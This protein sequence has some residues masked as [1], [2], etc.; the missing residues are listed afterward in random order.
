VNAVS[1]GPAAQST[2]VAGAIA[3]PPTE[4]IGAAPS[5]SSAMKLTRTSPPAGIWAAGAGPHGTMP[6]AWLSTVKEAA[7]CSVSAAAL[8]ARSVTN[9][10]RSVYVPLGTEPES[11]KL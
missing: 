9:T 1:P 11:E 4:T 6:G 2:P 8:P 5:S 10:R 3:M 7:G